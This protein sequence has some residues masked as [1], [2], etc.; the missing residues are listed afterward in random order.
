MLLAASRGRALH[1]RSTYSGALAIL[2]DREA[3]DLC[4]VLAVAGD[5]LEVADDRRAVAG[6][7]HTPESPVRGHG[8]R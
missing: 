5:E 4:L 2:A 7:Q 8:R 3:L 1:E 6:H